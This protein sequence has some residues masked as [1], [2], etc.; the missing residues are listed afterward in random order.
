MHQSTLRRALARL[1]RNARLVLPGLAL[2]LTLAAVVVPPPAT[3]GHP[4]P[5]GKPIVVPPPPAGNPAP[6]ERPIVAPLVNW[7]S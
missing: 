4:A 6:V 3:D 2:A 1:R 7:N 5:V